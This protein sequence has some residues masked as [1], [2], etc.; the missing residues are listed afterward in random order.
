MLV[1]ISSPFGGRTRTRVLLALQL[2]GETYPRE[3]A[4]LLKAPIFGV[5]KALLGL[6]KDGLVAAR[7]RGRIRLFVLN[8][9]YPAVRELQAYLEKLVEPDSELKTAVLEMRRRPRRTGK[10]A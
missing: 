3:L 6:E 5:Q 8:P 9:R 4:R 1:G 10:V 7:T 2:L